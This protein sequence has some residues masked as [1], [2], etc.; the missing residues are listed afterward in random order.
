MIT[1]LWPQ[2]GSSWWAVTN[3][4]TTEFT[5]LSH[6]HVALHHSTRRFH[7]RKLKPG[8]AVV[9]PSATYCNIIM[10]KYHKTSPKSSYCQS[11]WWSINTWITAS[12]QDSLGRLPR[13]PLSPPLSLPCLTHRLQNFVQRENSVKQQSSVV[14]PLLG[15]A[16]A[17]EHEYDGSLLTDTSHLHSQAFSQNPVA[18]GP[19]V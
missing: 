17:E 1:L 14:I 19:P 7:S 11:V 5:E 9:S 12:L 18:K 2:K 15:F 8:A 4:E 3:F 10:H 16:S 13:L 6:V